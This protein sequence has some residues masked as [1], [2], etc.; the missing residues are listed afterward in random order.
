LIN[1]LARSRKVELDVIATQFGAFINTDHLKD[2]KKDLDDLSKA[3]G[4]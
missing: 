1:L 3:V 4:E 2:I